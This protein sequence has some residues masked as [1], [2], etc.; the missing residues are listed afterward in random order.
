[1]LFGFHFVNQM[2]AQ[3]VSIVEGCGNNQLQVNDN[4]K[5][6]GKFFYTK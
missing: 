6:R 4:E 3:S 1:M 5:S 2:R